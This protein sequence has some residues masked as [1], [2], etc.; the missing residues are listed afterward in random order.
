MCMIFLL[1]FAFLSGIAMIFSPCIWPIL[2]IVMATGSGGAR[3]PL[4]IIVGLMVSFSILTLLISVIL[5]I[6]PIH[7][8]TLR[9][10]AA[11]VIGFFGVTMV[12]PALSLFLEGFLSRLSSVS[13]GIMD[14]KHGFKGGLIIGGALGVAWSP[15]AGP[16]LATVGALAATQSVTFVL[17]LVT[18]A[19]SLG[20]ALPLFGLSL[21]GR[22]L[23][24]HTRALA[25]YTKMMQQVFGVLVILSVIA[26]ATGY[27]LVLQVRFAEFCA[28][29]GLSFLNRLES[30]PLVTEEL[31][32]LREGIGSGD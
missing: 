32:F 1:L 6:I 10:L 19:F 20:M 5:S 8:E 24:E 4:G 9:L 22:H 12:V 2:P 27:D 17:V 26:L 30:N 18:L 25:P 29:N 7:P 11:F 31:E 28:E 23:I 13:G 21:L 15:C 3:R 14:K 16:I